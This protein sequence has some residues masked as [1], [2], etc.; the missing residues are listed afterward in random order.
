MGAE[1]CGQRCATCIPNIFF[2]MKKLQIKQIQDNVSLAV[3]KS[4]LKGKKY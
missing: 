4:K 3:R 1:E 2:K